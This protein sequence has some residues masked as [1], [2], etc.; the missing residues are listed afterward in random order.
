MTRGGCVD[1]RGWWPAEFVSHAMPGG[2]KLHAQRALEPH[3]PPVKNIANPAFPNPFFLTFL[4]V[5]T[6]AA[7]VVVWSPTCT[8]VA[9]P[10]AMKTA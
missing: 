4:S 2:Y 10:V 5:H 9:S 8:D 6:A 7:E 3:F 1:L